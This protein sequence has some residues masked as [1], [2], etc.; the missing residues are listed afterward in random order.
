MSTSARVV[1][2]LVLLGLA[3]SVAPAATPKEIDAAIKKGADHLKAK[4]ARGNGGPATGGDLGIGPTCLTGLALLEAGTP[5]TDQSLKAIT[6]AVRNASYSAVKT[7][8]VSLCLMF[9]DRLG[10]P[11]DVPLIQVLAVRLLVGQTANGGWGYDCVPAVPAGDV[12][13]LRAL[14]AEVPPPKTPKLYPE[15][16]RYAQALAGARPGTV[17]D[18][19][20]NTQ[21]A[22]IGVWLARKHGVPVET[23]LDSIETRF[24]ATQ[25]PRTAGWSYSGGMLAGDTGMGG[26]PSMY[27]A[28]LIG[29]STGIARREERRHKA[30]AKKE[31]SLTPPAGPGGGP[32]GKGEDDPFFN[33]APKAGPDPKKPVR[34]PPDARDR[35][36]MAAFA[37]LGGIVAESARAGNGALVLANQG[38]HGH[39]DLYFFWSLERAC[40]IYGVEKLG[41]ID[42]YEAGAETLVRAQSQDGSWQSSGYADAG[43]CFAIL[44]LCRS[45]LARD[46]SGRVQNET[47]TEMRAGA[48]PTGLPTKLLDPTANAGAN[49]SPSAPAL[50]GVTGSEAAALAAELLRAAPKEKDWTTVLGKLRDSK[51][52]N[53]T[54][55]LVSAMNRLEGDRLKA[56]RS[57]L[58]ERLTRMT[59]QTLREMARSEEVELRRGAVLAMAMKD[60]K[61]H[62]PDLIAALE[63]TEEI[64]VRAARAGLES[65][66]GQNFGPPANANLG[67]KKIAVASWEDWLSKQK[68]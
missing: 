67:Q 31:E 61:A 66:T 53:Y 8:Q 1:L 56:A 17:G 29:L 63:D 49:T 36:V 2:G 27:C 60:D 43:T 62:I 22:V 37:A 47:A 16:Q 5:V 55:A 6:E 9:L 54:Q 58:A 18:D 20:S 41:G 46:L 45:N 30:E 35:A 33:P 64:V 24:L 28:G 4:Y 52:G 13:R 32:G 65:L 34:R 40:V 19:N 25:S 51:G 50:P 26:S 3:S 12:E 14:K 68:K 57:A 21:F 11:V 7:Y 48:G 39:N 10:D 44:F 15:V 42:W 59:T 23:A 38:G